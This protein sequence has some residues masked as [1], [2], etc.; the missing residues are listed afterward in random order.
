MPPTNHT[1]GSSGDL[2]RSRPLI[3]IIIL[4]LDEAALTLDCIASI[5]QNTEEGT[6]EIIV[7]DNGSTALEAEKLAKTSACAF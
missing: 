3:S 4:N 5:V 2:I 7:V 1:S 6:Y